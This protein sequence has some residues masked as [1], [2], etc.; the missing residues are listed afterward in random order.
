MPHTPPSLASSSPQYVLSDYRDSDEDSDSDDD[1]ARRMKRVP[2]WA[3]GVKLARLLE[4][5]KTIKADLIFT[6]EK[7]CN[8]EGLI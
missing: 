8:L 5:Q 2:S 4:R 1:R 7:T 6:L 3:K